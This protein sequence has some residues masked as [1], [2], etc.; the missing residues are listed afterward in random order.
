MKYWIVS[1]VVVLATSAL[2]VRFLISSNHS[3][4]VSFVNSS[5]TAPQACYG[6][7]SRIRT[8]TCSF[9][10][11]IAK[12]VYFSSLYCHNGIG[13]KFT[14]G[15]VL[16]ITHSLDCIHFPLSRLIVNALKISLDYLEIYLTLVL[17]IG[18]GGGLTFPPPHAPTH[19]MSLRPCFFFGC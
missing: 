7:N 14:K 13:A 12:R 16:K 11:N 9:S 2:R 18:G 4:V 1:A 19:T 17:N 10:I 8:S 15:Y 6:R 3:V 5:F